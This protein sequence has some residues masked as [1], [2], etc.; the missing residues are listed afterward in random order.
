MSLNT[1]LYCKYSFTDLCVFSFLLNT[2]FVNKLGSCY[3][4]LNM[5]T[6]N[7]ICMLILLNDDWTVSLNDDGSLLKQHHHEHNK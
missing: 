7:D 1:K 2:A 6:Q 3:N 5:Q 4:K